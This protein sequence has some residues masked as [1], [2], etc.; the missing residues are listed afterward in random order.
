MEMT[1]ASIRHG[2][3]MQFASEVEAAG[4]LARWLLAALLA[5]ASTA[6]LAAELYIVAGAEV[7]LSSAEVRAAFL[8]ERQFAGNI[9]LRVVDNRAARASFVN[10]VLGMDVTHYET[11]WTRKSFR[12][13][14][15]PPEMRSSDRDVLSYIRKHPGALGYVHSAPSGANVLARY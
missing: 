3:S 1:T 8:G 6:V 13:G 11:H 12:E 4:R 10:R 9:L 14:L 15:H 7:Q 2:S 5:A